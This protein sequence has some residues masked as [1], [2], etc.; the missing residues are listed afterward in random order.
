MLKN[1]IEQVLPFQLFSKDFNQILN[2]E[3]NIKNPL[4]DFD[5]IQQMRTIFSLLI[6]IWKYILDYYQRNK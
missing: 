2:D 3:I 5:C 6:T 4:K 1:C